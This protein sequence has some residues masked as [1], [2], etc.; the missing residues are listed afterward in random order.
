MDC[1]S[2]GQRAAPIPRGRRDREIGAVAAVAGK[3]RRRA[4]FENKGLGTGARCR[5]FRAARRPRRPPS[6]SAPKDG[7]NPELVRH[8]MK[9]QETS[10]PRGA[11]G[12]GKDVVLK[13][14][15]STRPVSRPQMAVPGGGRYIHTFS[16]IVTRDPDT[17]VMNVGIYR[18]MVSRPHTTPFLLIKGGQHWGQ[19]FVKYAAK[20]EPMPVACIIGWDP[21]MPF[22]AGSPIPAGVCEYDVMGAYRG[23]PASS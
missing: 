4:V 21:I 15:E 7:S 13:G 12:P 3:E 16:A 14:G 19:H 9:I 2:K 20:G 10:R 11:P 23:E 22:L 5:V 8:V 18:G 17:R 6:R 1:V